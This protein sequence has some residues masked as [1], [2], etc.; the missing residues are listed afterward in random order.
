MDVNR[1][2]NS[3]CYMS[4]HIVGNTNEVENTNHTSLE[5]LR[6]I[7]KYNNSCHDI[8]TCVVIYFYSFCDILPYAMI[9]IN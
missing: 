2:I 6:H 7:V 8:L 1:A 9:Y 4:T 5:T 3:C